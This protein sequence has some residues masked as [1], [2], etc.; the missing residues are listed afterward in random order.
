VTVHERMRNKWHRRGRHALLA[1]GLLTVAGAGAA[2]AGYRA[3]PGGC[4]RLG[5]GH[6][7]MRLYAEFIV[8]RALKQVDATDEQRQQ[9]EA[10]TGRLLDQRAAMHAEHERLHQEI[11]ALLTAEKVD[12]KQLEALRARQLEKIEAASRQLT[13]AV[14]DIADVLTPE[15]R[16]K[17]LESVHGLHG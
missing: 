7:G 5:L 4:H 17:L 11:A 16:A 9:V 14:A 3:F 13:Q 12:R 2:W 10:I 1:L 6:R 15:Q 8:E